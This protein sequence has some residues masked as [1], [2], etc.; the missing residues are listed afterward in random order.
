VPG[1]RKIRLVLPSIG[2]FNII[3]VQK[4][5]AATEPA[6]LMRLERYRAMPGQ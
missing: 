3:V 6:R 4:S 5:A 2:T 1:T